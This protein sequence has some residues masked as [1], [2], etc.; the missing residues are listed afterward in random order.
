MKTGTA[1]R[2]GDINR[3]AFLVSPDHLV[4]GAVIF[5]EPLD[6][7]PLRQRDEQTPGKEQSN[8]AIEQIENDQV[9]GD[10]VM[11][12][13]ERR[14]V[15]REKLVEEDKKADARRPGSGPTPNR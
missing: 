4:F 8:R 14:Q 10:G 13:G 5:E 6:I 11:L 1:A 12:L 2:R 3:A 9:P 7:L 15:E